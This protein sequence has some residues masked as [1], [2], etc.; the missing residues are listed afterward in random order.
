MSKDKEK[1]DPTIPRYT[2]NIYLSHIKHLTRTLNTLI[3]Y[4]SVEEIHISFN[5]AKNK[6]QFFLKINGTF[7]DRD[8]TKKSILIYHKLIANNKLNNEEEILKVFDK[9]ITQERQQK[10]TLNK[11]K[12]LINQNTT[13]INDPHNNT[14]FREDISKKL[15]EIKSILPSN[16]VS[17]FIPKNKDKKVKTQVEKKIYYL[18]K[19]QLSFI[20]LDKITSL[21]TARKATKK[22]IEEMVLNEVSIINDSFKYLEHFPLNDN[23]GTINEIKNAIANYNDNTV[24]KYNLSSYTL[25]ELEEQLYIAKY[26]NDYLSYVKDIQSDISKQIKSTFK[27]YFTLQKYINTNNKN[28]TTNSVSRYLTHITKEVKKA[29]EL[30][31]IKR[32]KAMFEL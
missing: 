5:K 27:E 11:L 21:E 4:E 22:D 25:E 10:Q 2:K 14:F 18:I 28:F 12:E 32:R 23:M 16:V 29:R 8:Y 9:P 24:E 13:K 26:S 31:G 19:N 15:D 20:N 6:Y 7:E 30:R 17:E 1:K 3:A